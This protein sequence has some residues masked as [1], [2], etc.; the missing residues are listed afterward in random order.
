MEEDDLDREEVGKEGGKR[1]GRRSPL[2]QLAGGM[3]VFCIIGVVL[4]AAGRGF[5]PT[6]PPE[7]PHAAA[8]MAGS[9]TPASPSP[10]L[11]RSV[12]YRADSRGQYYVDAVVNGA[13]LHFLV[14]TGASYVSLTPKD[15][16][17]A[18]LSQ[19]DLRFS[20]P[21]NT[22]HGVAHA[23]PVV[24][25]EIRLQQLEL[26]DVAAVVM[27]Q[28]MATSVLGMSFLSRLDGY[29][30]RDGVLTIEW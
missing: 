21:L 3:V 12:S 28:P 2:F 15:A 18:G 7:R 22:A 4:V 29:S 26:N 9:T 5:I 8:M 24:L 13:R 16:A 30:I 10:S 1:R 14:D 25:R 27:D 23:A 6:P 11:V 20:M 17:F 19:N